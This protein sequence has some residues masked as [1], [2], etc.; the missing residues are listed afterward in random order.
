LVRHS[1]ARKGAIA[2]RLKAD[3]KNAK[4]IGASMPGAVV[5][6]AVQQGDK[7]VAGQ[8]L[9]TLEAMKM[10]TTILADVGGKIADVHVVAGAHVEA[11]DL[12]ITMA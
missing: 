8:K 9:L 7:I 4:Q 11:G 6:V 12:L 2:E 1:V 10:E 5:V 3:P